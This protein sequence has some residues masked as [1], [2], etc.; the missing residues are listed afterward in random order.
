MLSFFARKYSYIISEMIFFSI[1]TIHLA[2]LRCHIVC[3]PVDEEQ[4]E[5]VH[6][7]EKGLEV[8]KNELF[9]LHIQT[10]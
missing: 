7:L 8:G 9:L 6:I 4:F 1:E 3:K 5:N 2:E 10:K